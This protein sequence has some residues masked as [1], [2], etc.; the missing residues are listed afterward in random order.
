MLVLTRRIG[1]RVQINQ[2]VFVTVIAIE[3]N[4]VK[5][6]FDAPMHV[7]IVRD[8]LTCGAKPRDDKFNDNATS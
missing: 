8:E 6:G 1:E 7:L 4:Q 3:G 2:D 5:L